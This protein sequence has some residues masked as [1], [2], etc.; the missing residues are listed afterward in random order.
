GQEEVQQRYMELQLL[1]SQLKQVQQQL[2]MLTQQVSELNRIDEALEE[3]AKTKKETEVLSQLGSGVFVKS[4]LMDEKN[5]L[6]NVGANI[7]VEKPIK[8]AKGI[9]ERQIED[10]NNVIAELTA[11]LNGGIQR[12]Q[13]LQASGF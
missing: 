10:F 2:E 12:M 3:L 8:D 13:E 7:V 4:V 6:L 9:V 11:Q 1:N 5:V